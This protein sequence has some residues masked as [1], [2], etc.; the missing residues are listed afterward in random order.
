MERKAILVRQA[1]TLSRPAARYPGDEER[2]GIYALKAMA[3]SIW[4]GPAAL[5]IAATLRP[6]RPTLARLLSACA[7]ME[8]SMA[9]LA[10]G[11][12]LLAL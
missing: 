8:I 11:V 5:E 9:V 2:L 10:M 6:S 4:L 1:R 3:R 12:A 7:W